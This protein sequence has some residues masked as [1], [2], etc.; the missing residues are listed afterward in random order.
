MKVCTSIC[1]VDITPGWC[2]S[3]ATA[4]C[5]ARS[6]GCALTCRG[7]FVEDFLALE[8]RDKRCDYLP[9]PCYDRRLLLRGRGPVVC[10]AASV[11]KKT[12]TSLLPCPATLPCLLMWD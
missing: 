3:G 9:Q 2:P 5:V 10:V 6:L 11:R 7:P 4:S 12:I 8:V 1:L